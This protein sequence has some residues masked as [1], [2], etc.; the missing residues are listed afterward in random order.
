MC[1]G[2]NA[3]RLRLPLPDQRLVRVIARI[4]IRGL[5]RC[6]VVVMFSSLSLSLSQCFAQSYA[7][8]DRMLAELEQQKYTA[9]Q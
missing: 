8:A 3:P 5:L 9:K 1:A 2:S 7:E 6:C 4:L